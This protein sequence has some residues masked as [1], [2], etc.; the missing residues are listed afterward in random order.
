[1]QY[2]WCASLA[3]LLK[4]S[5]HHKVYKK[6]IK[7]PPRCDI[8]TGTRLLDGE[9]LTRAAPPVASSQHHPALAARN[10][11]LHKITLLLLLLLSCCP[12]VT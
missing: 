6:C 4:G 11:F 2:H 12:S 1:M 10:T 3:C 5:G 7:L 8:L 9:K